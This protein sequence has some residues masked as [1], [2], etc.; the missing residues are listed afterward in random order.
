MIVDSV[1]TLHAAIAKAGETRAELSLLVDRF[2]RNETP[3]HSPSKSGDAIIN[4]GE[5]KPPWMH[6]A[7]S[8]KDT[9]RLLI[10]SRVKE[11]TFLMRVR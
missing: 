10:S 5:T 8:R 7:I 2:V 4:A 9:E 3:L 1:Q 6:G 11:G